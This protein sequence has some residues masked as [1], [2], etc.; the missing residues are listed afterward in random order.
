MDV[1]NITSLLKILTWQKIV[2][3]T[4][5]VVILGISYGF[6][7][8]RVTIY[9]SLRVGAR[10][11]V[12][13]PIVIVLSE[14]TTR[15]LD[16][17]LQKTKGMIS[18]IQVINVDFKKNTR[19]TAFFIS[20]DPILRKE[21]EDFMA[22]KVT[23]TALF[24]SSE[25]NN[26]K[27]I[28]LINGEFICNEFKDTVAGKIIPR[29]QDTISVVC[30]ISIPPYYGRFSGYLNLYL[31]KKPSPE[32]ISIIRQIARDLSL[33]IY[34]TDVDKSSKYKYEKS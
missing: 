17:S 14:S 31:S 15:V 7:E 22:R 21:L 26:Q 2:Q 11:E 25:V 27:I 13:Q 16:E 6:W 24:N 33:R 10:V 28:N 30:S 3:A 20:S 29:A 9:N 32:E 12:E 1:K 34:E 18:G 5:L 19:S 4:I 8:N 23:D